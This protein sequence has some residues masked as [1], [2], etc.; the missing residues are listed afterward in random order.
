[1][2]AGALGL[3]TGL[4]YD[5]GSYA[6]TAEVVALAR[7]AARHGGR[8]ISHVRKPSLATACS[9]TVTPG[10]RARSRGCWASTCASAACCRWRTRS[11]A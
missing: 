1:M 9:A 5:P 8:Y 11:V 2:E 10:A 7:E 4:E 3:S 6:E